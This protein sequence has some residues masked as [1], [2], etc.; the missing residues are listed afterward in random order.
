[1][2]R[3]ASAHVAHE[4]VRGH[5]E[6]EQ[7]IEPASL[8]AAKCTRYLDRLSV[9]A[10]R[11]LERDVDQPFAN[12]LRPVGFVDDDVEMHAVL[13]GRWFGNAWEH[14]WRSVRPPRERAR[15]RTCW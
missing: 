10:R 5:I 15:R 7:L 1:M 4:V 8:D 3:E 9:V 11:S 13:G 2:L 14:E 12:S 6:A